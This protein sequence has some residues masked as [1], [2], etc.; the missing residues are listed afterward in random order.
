MMGENIGPIFDNQRGLTVDDD[1]VTNISNSYAHGW[2]MGGMAEVRGSIPYALAQ[3]DQGWPSFPDVLPEIVPMLG[4]TK[5][6]CDKGFSASHPA[7]V[8]MGLADGSIRN[9]ARDAFWETLYQL[10]GAQDGEVPL[11]Y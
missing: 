8:N 6:A 3:H 5:F 7:G 10:G 2:F 11:N 4:S 1:D 9:V